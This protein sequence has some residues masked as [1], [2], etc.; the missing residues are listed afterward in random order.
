MGQSRLSSRALRVLVVLAQQANA[1]GVSRPGYRRIAQLAGL[2]KN[3]IRGVIDELE[4][5]R[6]IV[7]L[8]RGQG[9]CRYRVL[10]RAHLRAA[11]A[12]DR[13]PTHA[14]VRRAARDAVT[15]V[16]GFAGA[17]RHGRRSLR[18]TATRAAGRLPR[19][20]LWITSPVLVGLLLLSATAAAEALWIHSG[21]VYLLYIGISLLLGGMA[22]TTLVWMM[23]AW[24]TPNSPAERGMRPV[25]L[26][27]AHSFSLIVPARHEEAVLEATLSRLVS[28]DHPAFEVLVVVG[29]DDQATREVAEAAA[30]RHPHLVKVIVDSSWPKNK[31]RALNAALPHC[32]GTIT[33]VFDAEDDGASR[34][35]SA[36][37]PD[38]SE[39]PMRTSCRP[40]SS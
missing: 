38:V 27:P 23:D 2:N 39:R 20:R 13:L 4:G 24:R 15:G 30:D 3:A 8:R 22:T 37:R 9:G 5:S 6:R 33:G 26:D 17:A 32:T 19:A 25:E 1:E 36:D 14:R 12:D 34:T 10:E 31:P 40:A 11:G 29:A 7:V 21:F 16:A 18:P 35:A 28:T